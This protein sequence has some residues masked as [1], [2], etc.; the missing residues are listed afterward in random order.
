MRKG[1]TQEQVDAAADALVAA[2]ERP[3]VDR[4]RTVLGTGSPNT[5]IRMLD[6]WRESLAKRMQELISLPDV[7]DEAGRAFVALWRLAVAHASS[8]AE[9]SLEQQRQEL[10]AASNSLAEERE[11]LAIELRDARARAQDAEQAREVAELRLIDLQR[12]AD[13]QTSQ[14]EELTRDRNGW[15]LRC[16]QSDQNLL[17]LQNRLASEQQAQTLHVRAVEDR[18]H[19]EV[20]RARAE[21]KSLEAVLRRRE[22]ELADGATRL[23]AALASARSA[24]QIAAERGARG[25]TLEEQLARMDGLPAALLAAQKALVTATKRE[26]ALQARLNAHSAKAK[27]KPAGKKA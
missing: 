13:Q 24:E 3:T 8:L 16:E 1:I 5:V 12:L 2:G 21:V 20:D 7:P 25:K 23:E 6:H 15:Q 27:E 19:A 14:L 17:A 18:A 11:N 10:R 26:V 22:R 9:A 4:I